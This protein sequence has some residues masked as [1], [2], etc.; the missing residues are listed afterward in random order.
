MRADFLVSRLSTLKGGWIMKAFGKVLFLAV[1]LF[2][3]PAHAADGGENGW[4]GGLFGLTVP[5]A[6]N[7]TSRSMY[8]ITAGAK[9]GSEYGIGVYYLTSR[10]NET[11]YGV[12]TPFNYDLYGV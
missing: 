11:I 5:N 7:T 10:Q 8:G 1:L 2:Q 9:L 6:D 12:S 4:V 3:I